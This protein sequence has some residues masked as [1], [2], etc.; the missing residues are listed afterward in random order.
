MVGIGTAALV[1]FSLKGIVA[2]FYWLIELLAFLVFKFLLTIRF[3]H[4][5]AEM[6]SREF[7]SLS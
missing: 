1:F 5:S 4:V 7:I 3:A 2:L 6:R